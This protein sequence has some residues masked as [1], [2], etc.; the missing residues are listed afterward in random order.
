MKKRLI[1]SVLILCILLPMFAIGAS[2][3]TT[4]SISQFGITWTF[5]EAVE[6]GQFANGDYWVVGPVTITSITPATTVVGGAS[7]HGS[8]INPTPNSKQGFDSRINGGSYDA[9]L[10][11]AITM[12]LVVQPGSSLLSCKS[13]EALVGNVTND[14][15]ME[16]LAILTILAEPAPEGSFRP[17]YAGDDKALNWNKSQLD[18]TR[19][20]SLPALAADPTRGVYYVPYEMSL[21]ESRFERPWIEL[22]TTWVG[23]NWHPHLNQLTLSGGS[24]NYGR[25]IANTVAAGLLMLQLDYSK[26]QKETLLIRMVQYGID[27]Y[28]VAKMGAKWNNDGGHN[29]GRK[30]PLLLAG[31]ALGD[32]NILEY[33]DAAKHFIF[34]ED[35]QT[36]Y[37]SQADVDRARH[38]G[39]GRQRDPYTVDM[40]GRPEWGEKHMGQPER[41]GSNWGV[42]YRSLN[43][44]TWFGHALTAH[45]MGLEE[46]W[47]WSA[48]FDYVERAAEID[49]YN[50]ASD[51]TGKLLLGD[52]T[53]F[54]YK[55]WLTYRDEEYTY[56]TSIHW[57]YVVHNKSTDQKEMFDVIYRGTSA[58]K[59]VTMF[60]ASYN[61]DGTLTAVAL[62]NMSFTKNVKS[63]I[64]LDKPISA[65]SYKVFLWEDGSM[66]P[67]I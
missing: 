13:F 41:D 22:N 21:V 31:T 2:A 23:R 28:G 34:Q 59:A 55:M 8:M 36:F 37:I 65:D 7:M 60:V 1:G 15:Q 54:V 61:A 43:N 5:S 47:N 26:A 48:Y 52:I 19:L 45:I 4:T 24:G 56:D 14:S 6:Y 49:I 50:V 39:D 66:V 38:T 44:G 58:S 40:I 17:P 3:A 63:Q 27:I 35:Q 11:V 20:G 64:E 46:A 33:G 9:V 42:S 32:E 57:D 18:Y 25:E 53:G 30:M 12:P 62:E 29:M 51:D 10:N 16:T 67:L